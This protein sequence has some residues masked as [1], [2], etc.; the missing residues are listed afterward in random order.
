M[1]LLD[2]AFDDF[3]T[4]R[5]K[6]QALNLAAAE[7]NV[8]DFKP[9]ALELVLRAHLFGFY[10]DDGWCRGLERGDHLLLGKTLVSKRGFGKRDSEQPRR[11]LHRRQTDGEGNRPARRRVIKLDA[12][13]LFFKEQFE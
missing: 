3:N 12:V 10:L 5:V 7:I 8:S 1:E 11:L 13:L 6:R 2:H 4:R 9:A